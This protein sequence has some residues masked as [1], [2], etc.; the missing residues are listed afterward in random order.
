VQGYNAQAAVTE[1][2]ILI[3]AEVTVDSPD[4]G[5]LGPMVAATE[6][7]LAAIG[8]QAPQVV[9]ADAGYWH[10]VQMDNIVERGIQLLIPP[11]AGKRR[12]HP[13]RLGRRPVR[14]HAP[15]PANR[16]RQRALVRIRLVPFGV[17]LL[18]G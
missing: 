3:A 12:G 18:V 13:A 7:E 17:M 6:T 2:Q 8:S 1:T 16:P 5:H 4:F 15:R 11:D 14:V 10:Q 9:V